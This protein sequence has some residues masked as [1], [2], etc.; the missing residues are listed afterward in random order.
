MTL[1][2]QQTSLTCTFFS[3]TRPRGSVYFMP[4]GMHARFLEYHVL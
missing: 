4:V 1:S 2:R 3:Q